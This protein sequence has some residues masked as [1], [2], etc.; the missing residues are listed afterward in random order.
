M[1]LPAPQELRAMGQSYHFFME[2]QRISQAAASGD[3]KALDLLEKMLAECN[4]GADWSANNCWCSATIRA[5]IS[6][7]SERGRKATIAYIES[8]KEDIPYG[9][10]E[11]I[12]SLLPLYGNS[13][14]PELRRWFAL[15]DNEPPK[16]IAVQTLCNLYL[17]RQMQ[18]ELLDFFLKAIADYNPRHSL[19]M[20]LVD[21]VRSQSGFS[22]GA[23]KVDME[24]F[25]KDVIVER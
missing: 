25:M 18:G 16:L 11:L 21:L 1:K 13:I 8:L 2:M 15:P 10:L 3:T 9:A 4:L 23:D 12:S 22:G 20:H 5:V 17:E 24:E 6:S 19:T 7:G 14:A